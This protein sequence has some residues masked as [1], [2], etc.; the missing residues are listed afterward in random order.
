MLV[1]GIYALTNNVIVTS[2]NILTTNSVDIDLKEY[3]VDESQSENLYDGE[4]ITVYPGSKISIVPKITNRG[5]NCYVRAKLDFEIDNNKI[6][7]SNNYIFDVSEKWKKYGDYYY[8]NSILNNNETIEIFN[9]IKIPSNLSKEYSGKNIIVSVTADAIQSDNFNPDYT[10]EDPW[11]NIKIEKSVDSTYVINS[12]D[13]NFSAELKFENNAEKYIEISE[14]FFKKL[15][16][17]VPG[18]VVEEHIKLIN[19]TDK[20]TE[21][22]YGIETPE[23]T[24]DSEIELLKKCILT[25]EKNDNATLYSDG[26]LNHLNNSIGKLKPG[27]EANVKFT[28]QIPKELGNSFSNLNAKFNWKFSIQPEEIKPEKQE[29]ENQKPESQQPEKNTTKENKDSIV[30]K[31]IENITKTPKTGDVKFDISLSVFL[32]SA[33]VLI[34]VLFLER[35]IKKDT[36]QKR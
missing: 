10:L 34:I 21:Y 23:N 1:S 3:L 2:G 4:N 36:K 6:E 26:L 8:F 19:K 24:K 35:R 16:K 28:I 20:E 13:E 11:Y 5:S 9:K 30:E 15:N 33:I 7:S 14:D 22:F 31:F 29:Q 18:D 27:E 25:V 32:I 12:K 17:M